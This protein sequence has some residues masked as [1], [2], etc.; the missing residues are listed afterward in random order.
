MNR[1]FYTILAAQ[2]FS[3]LA[4]NAL[5]F[6]AIALLR[7]MN[8]PEWQTPVLQQFFVFAYIVLA[9]FVGPFADSLPKGRV[10][11]ISNA[12]KIGGCITMLAGM[13]P[14]YAYGLV[15][16]GAAMYSPAKYG[17][18]T[19][20]LP[21]ARLVLA[22]GWM[23]GLTVLSIILGAI[24]GGVMIGDGFAH[25]MAGSFAFLGAVPLLDTAPE[26]AIL[27]ILLLYL[28]AALINL[29]IP[30]V[31]PDHKTPLRDPLFLLR[32]FWRSFIQLWRDPLGQ[33]SLAVTTLFWGTGATLR[34][35]VLLWAG[36]ALGFDVEKATQLTA[37]VAVG[38][39]TGSVLA[40]R[41][42]KL[43]RAVRVL[44]VGILMGAIVLTMVLITDWRAALVLLTVIG[45]AG[46]FFVV[47]MNALLQH[48]GHLIMGAGHSIAV[49]NFNENLSILA[50]LGVY[51]LMLRADV[52]LNTIIVSFGL[53]LM[54]TMT[55]LW[56]RHSH[57]QDDPGATD[58]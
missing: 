50:L 3:A 19:E 25:W 33:V 15:G 23:E 34:L 8:A 44:P 38:I 1:G 49:Q 53:L 36:A 14:L 48:R 41:F 52:S 11:F 54:V 17:I 2:F 12:I 16:V 39:A 10:M 4:D 18:L 58:R 31:V 29:Y 42:V 30:R 45:V 51:A 37:V 6:A 9:P 20:Y 47:P 56:R 13:Q 27:L 5:L 24:V 28:V 32:D 35:I 40:A 55:V 57:S 46:G 21:A 22:N 43:E 7:D 26:I